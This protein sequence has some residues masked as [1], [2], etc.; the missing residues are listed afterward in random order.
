MS[1]AARHA[2][3]C[4]R[5]RLE[6]HRRGG[7]RRAARTKIPVRRA[8]RA[9]GRAQRRPARRR[10]R[11][12]AGRRTARRRSTSRPSISR[13]SDLAFF[14][15]RA[16]L[17]RALCR[18][19]GRACLGDRQLVGL[20]RAA[21]VPL[22]AAD[23]NAAALRGVG[24]RGLIALPGS[25]SVALATALAPLHALA[26]WSGRKSRP[27]RRSRA[28]AAR[29]WMSSPAKPCAMLSGKKAARAGRSGGK[30]PST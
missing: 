21:D 30:S 26:G 8:A 19:R 15:G 12:R 3:N 18:S 7:D 2:A 22:V 4:R 28:A 17:Q 24:A 16:A 5:R 13:A 6:S 20:S 23:V 1:G 27:I 11:A 29:R 9:R 25:A 14:C 10:T